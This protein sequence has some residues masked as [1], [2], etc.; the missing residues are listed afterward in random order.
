MCK[1]AKTP[2]TGICPLAE[3]KKPKQ[4]KYSNVPPPEEKQKKSEWM[5]QLWRLKVVVRCFKYWGGGGEC[6]LLH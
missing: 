4:G 1:V 2:K 6:I 5:F 3:E